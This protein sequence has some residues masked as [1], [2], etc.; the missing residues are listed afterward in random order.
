MTLGKK[1]TVCKIAEEKYLTKLSTHA[2]R[3]TENNS[4]NNK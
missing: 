4:N 1:Y 3:I 2:E